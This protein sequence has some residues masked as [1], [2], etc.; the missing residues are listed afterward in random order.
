MT[1]QRG[2]KTD[3]LL[4]VPQIIPIMKYDRIGNLNRTR[5]ESWRS[6]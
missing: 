2:G 1:R 3:G 5:Q 4:N 6:P